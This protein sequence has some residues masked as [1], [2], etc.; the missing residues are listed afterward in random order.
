MALWPREAMATPRS[1]AAR[2]HVQDEAAD[3]D[4]PRVARAAATHRV[5]VLGRE[6]AC[7]RRV[8]QA[9]TVDGTSRG[10][11]AVGAGAVSAG[12]Q[13]RRGAIERGTRVARVAPVVRG[14]TRNATRS[15]TSSARSGRPTGMSSQ[16]NAGETVSGSRVR[17]RSGSARTSRGVTGL[18]MGL[19]LPVRFGP[20]GPGRIRSA[21]LQGAGFSPA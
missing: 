16:R 15:A 8:A 3:A 7:V 5:V 9:P 20:H 18:A 12:V 19:T 11:R 2:P 10:D 1:A 13:R 6:P 17:G 4:D 14:E 21:A